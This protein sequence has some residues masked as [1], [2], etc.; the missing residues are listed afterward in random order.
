GRLKM[1]GKTGNKDPLVVCPECGHRF[2]LDEIIVGPYRQAW[3]RTAIKRI[4]SEL[5]AAND[6]RVQAEAKRLAAKENRDKDKEL[7][8]KDEV[9]RER[10]RQIAGLRRKV[11]A[12]KLPAGRAQALGDVREETLAQSLTSR[13]PQDDIVAISKRN[14]GADLLQS[15]RNPA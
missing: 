14:G 1:T 7:R 10:D 5:R 13:C 11:T 9:I 3:E 2:A 4:E 8:D 15:V 6:E 12:L